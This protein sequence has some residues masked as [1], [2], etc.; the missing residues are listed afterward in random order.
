M[1]FREI[2]HPWRGAQ[3]LHQ[4]DI[5]TYRDTDSNSYSDGNAYI[6]TETYTHTGDRTDTK[7]ASYAAAPSRR[8]GD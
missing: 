5:N 8:K 1:R 2:K 3:T 4:G 6:N 7:A